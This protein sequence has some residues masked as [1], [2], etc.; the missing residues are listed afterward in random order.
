MDF[1]QVQQHKDHIPKVFPS[2]PCHTRIL[3]VISALISGLSEC[4]L[5]RRR[6]AYGG[7]SVG[8]WYLC[9]IT[10]D[11]EW[12]GERYNPILVPATKEKIA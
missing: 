2:A 9:D 4:V 1:I 3:P 8:K 5:R 10:I 6:K 12:C 11:H 7:V